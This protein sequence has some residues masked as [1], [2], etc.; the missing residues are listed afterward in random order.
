MADAA[1]DAVRARGCANPVRTA[2]G[3]WV[4]CSSRRKL[5]C[6][7]CA[8]LYHGD[9]SAIGRSGIVGA[10]A[11]RFRFFFLTLTAPSFGR[12]HRVPRRSETKGQRCW[13]GVT[14][15]ADEAGLRGVPLDASTYDYDGQARWNRDAGALWS[16][17]VHRLRDRWPSLEFFMAREWQARGVLHVHALLRLELGERASADAVRE[18]AASAV[19]A[20][21]VDGALVEWGQEGTDC[22]PIRADGDAQRRAWYIAKALNYTLKDVASDAA[23]LPLAV[24]AHQVR[25][26][27]A[28]RRM[29][30][31]RECAGES[32]GNRSH[33]NFG[34]RG[35]VV[36]ASR[37]TKTRA[38]WSFTGLTRTKLRRARFV[39]W[40]LNRAT[41]AER[42]ARGWP[43]EASAI[44]SAATAARDEVAAL[45]PAGP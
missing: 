9:W 11:S 27:D 10:D 36:S 1:R 45:C 17:T 16:N 38:G 3:V 29:R 22:Q 43:G 23:E 41:A 14:H 37:R 7:G 20:S 44:E 42:E 21:K 19:A 5:R 4:R 15:A 24:W 28:A 25:L 8:S 18:R 26:A 31:S 13:C 40:L 6:E 39:W 32:C 2:L 30:C 35:H 12:V 34:A 33:R